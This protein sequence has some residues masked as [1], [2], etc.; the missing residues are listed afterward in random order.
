MADVEECIVCAYDF[1]LEKFVRCQCEAFIC[2]ECAKTYMTTESTSACMNC[3]TQYAE[4]YLHRIMPEKWMQ[5]TY[6]SHIKDLYLRELKSNRVERVLEVERKKKVEKLEKDVKETEATIKDLHKKIRAST[7][8]TRYIKLTD[9]LDTFHDISRSL[10]RDFAMARAEFLGLNE[11]EVGKG[12]KASNF[13]CPCDYEDCN[14]LVGKNHRCAVCDRR[15]CIRC[16][17]ANPVENK[18]AHVCDPE[19]LAT[20]KEVRKEC[21]PCP[22]CHIPTDKI[23]G[24]NHMFCVYCRTF[25]DWETSE[26]YLNTVVQNPEATRLAATLKINVKDFI[27]NGPIVGGGDACQFAEFTDFDGSDE[28]YA[29][30]YNIYYRL[31]EIAQLQHRVYAYNPNELLI[32]YRVEHTRGTL[33]DKVYSDRVYAA[34]RRVN[35]SES[36]RSNL[37]VLYTVGRENYIYFQE[38]YKNTKRKDSKRKLVLSFLKQME[39]IRKEFNRVLLEDVGYLGGTIAPYVSKEWVIWGTR[40]VGMDDD[41]VHYSRFKIGDISSLVKLAT[42]ANHTKTVNMTAKVRRSEWVDRLPDILPYGPLPNIAC[43]VIHGD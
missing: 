33:S 32:G 3:K 36:I 17:I 34:N 22:N 24:C 16:Q 10:S 35:R 4:A 31:A 37:G 5:S 18:T 1:T 28:H 27:K 41:L 39:T 21:K 9:Q 26:K 19:T 2:V 40:K 38:T 8:T 23:F 25:W 11:D 30:L 29:A 6:K 43:T 15:T 13:I 14:G 7:D 42:K 12:K 20:L